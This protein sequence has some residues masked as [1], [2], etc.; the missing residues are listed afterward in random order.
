[1]ARPGFISRGP[2]DDERERNRRRNRRLM[3]SET[4]DPKPE[5]RA[6]G[7]DH[8]RQQPASPAPLLCAYVYV[9]AIEPR[10]DAR[11]RQREARLAA[12]RWRQQQKDAGDE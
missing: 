5:A 10:L 6:Y 11:R 7:C 4:A 3:Q 9:M 2:G 8:C 1:M 12:Q